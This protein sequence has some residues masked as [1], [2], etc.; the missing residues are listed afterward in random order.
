MNYEDISLSV[1]ESTYIGI[2][3]LMANTFSFALFQ[4]E[5]GSLQDG[6]KIAN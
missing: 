4:A 1:A 2:T 3:N 6:K 5:N